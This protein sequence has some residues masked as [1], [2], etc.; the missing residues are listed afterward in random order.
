MKKV[1]LG[2]VTGIDAFL[3]L[4]GGMSLFVGNRTNEVYDWIIFI[5]DLL[6]L[7]ISVVSL[8]RLFAGRKNAVALSILTKLALFFLAVALDSLLTNGHIGAFIVLLIFAAPFAIGAVLLGRST[9]KSSKSAPVNLVGF[10]FECYPTD[11]TLQDVM[12]EY[13]QINNKQSEKEL[14]SE[15][16]LCVKKQALKPAAYFLYWLLKKQFMSE[17]FL[18]KVDADQIEAV[19]A[20]KLLPIEVLK[21][22]DYKLVNTDLQKRILPF[23]RDYFKNPTAIYSPYQGEEYFA[24]YLFDYYEFIKN[25]GGLFYDVDF[26]WEIC[27]KMFTRIEKRFQDYEGQDEYE[28]DEAIGSVHSEL[29]KADLMVYRGGVKVL[30][31]I[32]DAYIQRCKND[33]DQLAQSELEKLKRW[34]NESYCESEEIDFFAE[35]QPFRIY[36]FEPKKEE[37]LVYSVRGEA[38]FEEEH[39]ISFTVR[40]GKLL[41][42]DYAMDGSDP[43]S[44]VMTDYYA[45][46]CSDLDF[47]T[48][49]TE[50][51]LEQLERE[52]KLVKVELPVADEN[53]TDTKRTIYITQHAYNRILQYQ[54]LEEALQASSAGRLKGKYSLK[55]RDDIL[56]PLNIKNTYFEIKVWEQ[57]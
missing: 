52:G 18:S 55:F 43:Y 15:E 11:E 30:D 4:A 20:G 35:F 6:C 39:G 3:A 53:D 26:S 1:Y 17:D 31:N 37:D 44:I 5:F 14:S 22:Q 47:E 24:K 8:I 32:T 45:F 2:I 28:D 21:D 34:T 54:F 56:V 38:D 57:E 9:A 40:N 29:F 16:Q 46:L 51:Q 25:E 50:E 48:L 33:L 42:M 41:S 7:V 27:D 36:V 19:C 23:I 10:Q 13:L 49:K 12:R